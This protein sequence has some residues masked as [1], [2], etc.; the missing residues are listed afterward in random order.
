VGLAPDQGDAWTGRGL[1]RV[2][3][4]TYREAVADA[5]EALKRKPATPA[6]MH[7]LACIFAQALARVQADP[8]ARDQAA[9]AAEYRK[10]S[11][12]AIRQ[13]LAMMPAARRPVF[14]REQVVPDSALAPVRD[15]AEFKQLQKKYGGR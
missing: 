7:N 2:M 8:G 10:H 12:E 3:L 15:C 14:W 1:A 9:R 4:G 5:G 6:M 13:T 11:L